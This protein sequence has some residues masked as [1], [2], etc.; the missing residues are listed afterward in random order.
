MPRARN[1]RRSR[2]DCFPPQA[3]IREEDLAL[4]IA[5]KRLDLGVVLGWGIP[6]LRTG[7]VSWMAPTCPCRKLLPLVGWSWILGQADKQGL[8]QTNLLPLVAW[9]GPSQCAACG[10]RVYITDG[11]SFGNLLR[12][13][14]AARDNARAAT[15]WEDRSDAPAGGRTG[16]ND[17][18]ASAGG[19]MGIFSKG[20]WGGQSPQGKNRMSKAG[21]LSASFRSRMTRG[22]S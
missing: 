15:R 4:A 6:C 1:A 12:D 21:R 13:T 16:D 14:Q 3:V 2:K 8:G 20:S 5:R 7:T 19:V 11:V 9:L 18:R 17:V 22:R 10:E